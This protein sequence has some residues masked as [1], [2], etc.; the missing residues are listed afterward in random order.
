MVEL[1]RFDDTGFAG[2]ESA[3]NSSNSSSVDAHR[4]LYVVRK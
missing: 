4:Q 1:S 2:A 3:V